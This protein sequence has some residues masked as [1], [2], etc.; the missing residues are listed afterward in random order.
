MLYNPVI[1]C[2]MV[3]MGVKIVDPDAPSQEEKKLVRVYKPLPMLPK[4][5][6][7]RMR[8]ATRNMAD[9]LSPWALQQLAELAEDCEDP[10]TKRKILNDILKISIAGKSNE[11]VDPDAPT[12]DGKVIK[13]VLDELEKQTE[14]GSG[15]DGT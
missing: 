13:T 12:V 2:K 6:A 11:E 1:S 8:R 4:E 14:S 15:S 7:M 10:E 9:S 3:S 5:E